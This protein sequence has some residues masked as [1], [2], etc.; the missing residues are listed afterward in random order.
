MRH[1]NSR[2]ASTDIIKQIPIDDNAVRITSMDESPTIADT[3][4]TDYS[5]TSI[6]KTNNQDNE[7]FMW[8]KHSKG[9]PRKIM[10]KMGYD[11]QGF[12]KGREWNK[13]T[14]HDKKCKRSLFTSRETP[15]LIK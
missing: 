4:Y 11:R 10:T 14:H 6:T 8:E 5:N 9:F 7:T 1:H 13:R 12:G 15:C 3:V 2:N